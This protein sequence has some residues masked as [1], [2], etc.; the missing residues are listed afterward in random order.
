MNS[1]A[2]NMSNR[3]KAIAV[4]AL[5]CLSATAMTVPSAVKTDSMMSISASAAA[6]SLAVGDTYKGN[7]ADIAASGLK[8]VTFNVTADFTGNLSYGF[9]I[10]TDADPYW[11]EYDGKS[12]VDT[13]GGT[14]EVPGIEVPVT[15]GQETAITIDVSSLSL[16]YKDEYDSKYD[17]TFEFRNYYGGKVTVNS[18]TANG[19]STT[20][21]TTPDTPEPSTPSN[22][23]TP[24]SGS[25]LTDEKGANTYRAKTADLAA[26]GI[27]NITIVLDT[28][29][30]AGNFSY[31]FGISIADSPYW[32]EYDGKSWVDT[33]DGTVE[34]PGTDVAVNGGEVTIVIDTSKLALKYKDE[35]NSEWDGEFEFRNYYSGGNAVTIKSITANGTAA[36]SNPG[37]T[38]PPKDEHANA[39]KDGN[40][41]NPTSGSYTFKDNGNGTGTMTATQARQIEFETPLTLTKGYDE[42]TYAAEGKTPVE[43][44]DPINSHKFSYSSFDIGNVGSTV[45]IESLMATIQSDKDVKTFMYGGGMN[46]ENGSPADTESA[47]NAAGVATTKDAGYWYNDMGDEV[48]E[49]CAAAGVQFGI[50][51]G[52]GYFLSSEDNQLG[53]Y[54]NVFWDV[55]EEVKPYETSGDISF[56]YWY[57]V[58]NAEEYT[59]VEAVDLVGGVLTYTENVTFDYTGSKKTDVNKEIAAGK[60]SGE[61]SFADLGVA[62]NQD[63]HAVVFTVSAGSDLDKLVYGIGA[64]VG[65]DWKQWSPEDAAWDYVVLNSK[66]GDVQIAWIVPDGADLNE[67]YGNLQF[68][69]WYG[70]KGETELDS[71]TLKSVE[72][73]YSE[74]QESSES[75]E[76]SSESSEDS[77]DVE[78][79]EATLW[80]DANCDN[81]VDIIDVILMNRV[82]VGVDKITPQGV[83]NADVDQSGKIELNDSMNVL[84]LL[85]DLLTQ[86]DFPIK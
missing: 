75:S 50:T 28:G 70:G 25:T 69:Y 22:P 46:V 17:G 47:K 68:G 21:P 80:G 14:V 71:V 78:L 26:S 60:M 82:Y 67:E 32:M 4:A 53:S 39:I 12:W 29:S 84:R 24:T 79:P 1:N 54:F 31:G 65:E 15:A 61:L 48:V 63:V 56:Q 6:Q 76:E 9:G 36:P 55:P 35:N 85:V 43:G 45:T 16:K 51:P 77:S 81:E 18:V 38:D 86:A 33:K 52:N 23:S 20:T 73:F 66:S 11:F 2:K 74:S 57:G 41:K 37:T 72:V 49:E 44:V 83:A 59:E 8:T 3:V 7:T 34:V 58:E 64:S 5:M 27:N 10:G 42:E 30:Y 62:A 13:K 40:T 19:A